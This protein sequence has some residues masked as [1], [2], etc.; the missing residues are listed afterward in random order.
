MRRFLFPEDP[1]FNQPKF[2]ST[3]TWNV[4]AIT[5]V[6][7]SLVGSTPNNI[8]IDT[9][10]TVYTAAYSLNRVHIWGEGT[11]APQRNLTVGLAYPN[12]IFV[13]SNGDVY[14][15]NAQSNNRVDRWTLNATNAVV[16]M[17]VNESCYGLFVDRHEN[18]YCSKADANQVVQKA[19]GDATTVI[20]IRAGGITAG[21]TAYLLNGSRG[22]FVDDELSLYVADCYNNRIQ[23]FLSN[24]LNATT[25]AGTGAPVSSSLTCPSAV[26][27]DADKNFFIADKDRS[28]IFR[29]KSSTF[30]CIMG[31]SSAGPASNQLNQPLALSFDNVGNL[32]VV[33]TH[34]N[35][36]QKFSLTVGLCST[37]DCLFCDHS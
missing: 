14:V 9:S 31:C 10:N 28:R 37:C 2:C 22:I 13:T 36:I 34:N 35:R 11:V 23:F 20:T 7:S 6:N 29:L 24:Q 21:S 26:I 12:S 8:F 33:D 25:V 18:I 30:S 17:V 5:F 27:L 15:D 19:Y 16:A 1:F 4:N 32:F 3:P